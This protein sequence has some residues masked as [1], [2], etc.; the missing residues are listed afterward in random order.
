LYIEV[1]LLVHCWQIRRRRARQLQVSTV[2]LWAFLV[3]SFISSYTIIIYY[4]Y[5]KYKY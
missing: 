5:T 4:W 2:N 1:I 3:I